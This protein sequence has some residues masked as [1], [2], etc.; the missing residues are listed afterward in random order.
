MNSLNKKPYKYLVNTLLKLNVNIFSSFFLELVHKK[1]V[2]MPP[3]KEFTT[4]HCMF[5]TT[6]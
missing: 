1:G 4:E 5:G 3:K 2:K 6:N